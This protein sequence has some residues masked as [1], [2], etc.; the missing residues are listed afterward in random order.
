MVT[1]C[2]FN[3]YDC[4][5]PLRMTHFFS[6]YS[7]SRIKSITLV[8]L[9]ELAHCTSQ[10]VFP[11]IWKQKYYFPDVRSFWPGLWEV[12][13]CW[14]WS[15]SYLNSTLAH[16]TVAPWLFPLGVSNDWASSS[17]VALL[18]NIFLLCG[19]DTGRFTMRFSVSY[20]TEEFALEY[21]SADSDYLLAI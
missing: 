3:C 1:I 2:C 11:S 9:R 10:K 17:K 18:S 4:N 21:A 19:T 8:Y 12:L 16:V 13:L 5:N 20:C 15:E 14:N 7:L 6:K